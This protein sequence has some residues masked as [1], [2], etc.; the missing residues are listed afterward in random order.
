MMLKP[1]GLEV[2]NETEAG[3]P[4]GNFRDSRRLRGAARLSA[5]VGSTVP[6]QTQTMLRTVRYGARGKQKHVLNRGPD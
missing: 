6:R 2:A 5:T 4:L 3:L 1:R